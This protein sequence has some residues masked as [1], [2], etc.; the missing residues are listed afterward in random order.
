MELHN[1]LHNFALLSIYFS[2]YPVAIFIHILVTLILKIGVFPL[3]FACLFCSANAWARN[4]KLLVS[5]VG[6]V[7][8][9]LVF[10]FIFIFIL[11]LTYFYAA[12]Q[13]LT[14]HGTLS[15]VPLQHGTLSRVPL[16][17]PLSPPD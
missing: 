7:P 8:F 3:V 9:L 11:G 17:T 13:Y 5:H 2:I 15:H 10:H 14:Q 12:V 1:K 6:F 4:V 16:P